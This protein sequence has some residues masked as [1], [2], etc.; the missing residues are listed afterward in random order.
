MVLLAPTQDALQDLI[1]VCEVYDAKYNTVYN[2]K[3]TECT[4][5]LL[6]HSKMDNLT[7]A[8]I[9]GCAFVVDKFTYLEHVINHNLGD[10]IQKQM[11]R[12][13]V[14][15]NMVL[16]FSICSQKVQLE[17]FCATATSPTATR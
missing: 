2:A 12:L 13:T 1:S 17:L 4:V 6:T 3:K 11:T 7:S 14:V 15:C 9:N 8:W 16:R 5:V 10:D